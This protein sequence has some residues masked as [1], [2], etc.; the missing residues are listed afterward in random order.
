M[1]IWAK[2]TDSSV[3]TLMVPLCAAIFFCESLTFF[4]L[5]NYTLVTMSVDLLFVC[6]ETGVCIGGTFV[7]MESSV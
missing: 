2:K 3:H 1:K 5:K 4:Q 6:S 7:L